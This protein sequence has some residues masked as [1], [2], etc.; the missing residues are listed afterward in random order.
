MSS[1]VRRELASALQRLPQEQRKDLA[2]ALLK[3]GED[4]EDPMIPLL[5][6]YGIEPLVAADPAVGMQLAAV[7]KLPKVTEFIYRRL[8]SD[9]EGRN[10]ILRALAGLS[11]QKKAAPTQNGGVPIGNGGREIQNGG[12]PSAMGAGK[13]KWGA[14]SAMGAGN[15][16]WGRPHRQ[17]GGEI[18]NG[19][20][21]SAMGT[22]EIKMGAA[23]L[24]MGAGRFRSSAR[25]SGSPS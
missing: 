25:N 4:A 10:A 8:S 7:S 22:G 6:W 16:K 20:P 15:P 13:P 21:P 11:G 14:P 12:A 3:H 9:P 17:W 24:R 2:T 23:P 18:Q 5:V 1:I 19:A